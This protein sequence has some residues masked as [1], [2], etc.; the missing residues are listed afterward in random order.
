MAKPKPTEWPSEPRT[1][2]KHQIYTRYIH[3]WMG[4]ILQVFPSA[5]VV[6][7][8]AGPGRYSDGPSGSS[9]VIARALLE[10]TGRD[11]FNTLRLIC[12]EKRADRRDALDLRVAELPRHASLQPT[13]LPPSTFADA[14][15][16]IDGLA[17]PNADPLP[18]LWVLD[19]FD[20]KG[21]PFDLV[22]KCL[23]HPKDEV[24]ITWFADE[25]YRF[26]EV[27]Q[28][29]AALTD[30]YGGEHW[31]GALAS[32]GEHARKDALMTVYRERL[33]SLPNVKTGALSISSKNA[34]ARY[35]I[36][37][38]THSD[39]GLECWNP[40]K[41]GLDPAAGQTVSERRGPQ[42]A[43]FDDRAKLRQALRRRAGAAAS[44]EDL[45]V[46]AIRLG[47]MES[48]LRTTLDELS[49]EGF[50][51][52]ERPLDTA[53]RSPWPSDSLIRFYDEA[54]ADSDGPLTDQTPS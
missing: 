10:H 19:P 40:V 24:L 30:H 5:T 35:S 42:E 28:F 43:L 44:F 45:R 48:Q 16:R 1:L 18:T 46:E 49:E 29:Q 4:K 50:A 8:F 20:V 23:T 52:R 14:Q 17:H 53:A 21:L 6:D 3:C 2:L 13:V 9:I 27:P 39:K 54:D 26:C 37:L 7:A 34:S 15:P 11:R 22:A 25:I 32:A 41:W 47:F 51:V 36:I 31:R 33:E 12:N 38:A